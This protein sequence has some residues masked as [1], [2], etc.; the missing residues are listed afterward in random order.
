MAS[1]SSGGGF[2]RGGRPAPA[3]EGGDFF[4]LAALVFG[5]GFTIMIVAAIIAMYISSKSEDAVAAPPEV[6][7]PMVMEEPEAAT[8]D[9]AEGE[10]MTDG[11]G[12]DMSE[13][14]AEGAEPAMP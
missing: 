4:G 6:A 1:N 9:A 12:E 10:D 14:E 11:M 5:A 7:A 13:G 2:Q 3:P 8:E